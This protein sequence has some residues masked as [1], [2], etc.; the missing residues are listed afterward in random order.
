M[1]NRPL[2]HVVTL[3]TTGLQE[4]APFTNTAGFFVDTPTTLRVRRATPATQVVARATAR[5]EPV[6]GLALEG[7]SWIWYPDDDPPWDADDSDAEGTRYFRTTVDLEAAPSSGRLVFTAD[8]LAT[9]YVNGEEVGRSDEGFDD[10]PRYSWQHA[11]VVD[12]T[13]ALEA[14]ENALAFEVERFGNYAGLLGRFQIETSAGDRTVDTNGTWRAAQEASGDWATAD[15]DASDWS[16]ALAIG[17]YGTDPW[18]TNV[19]VDD[20]RRGAVRVA[21]S[22]PPGRETTYSDAAT[23][24]EGTGIRTTGWTE[25]PPTFNGGTARLQVESARVTAATLELGIRNDV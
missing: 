3:D 9:A 15:F 1:T 13:D 16:E 24:T 6:G 25:V 17:R 11:P 12:V 18:G 14:G 7:A 19:T 21:V 4:V 8:N 2:A 10:E 23:I 22:D 20:D 5:L